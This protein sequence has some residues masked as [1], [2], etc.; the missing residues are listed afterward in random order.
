[1][2]M[3]K[4]L[5]LGIAGLAF[6]ACSNEED[7]INNGSNLNGNGV[8]EVSIVSPT[9]RSLVEGTDEEVGVD[10]VIVNGPI[11]VQL[12]YGN[13]QTKS[14]TI[15]TATGGQHTVKFY[16][17][18]NPTKV[19]A[20][21]NGGNNNGLGTTAIDNSAMQVLPEVIPAYG[22]T[23]DINLAGKTEMVDGKT[24]EM[25]AAE[26]QIAIPVARLEVSGIKHVLHPYTN[27]EDP[28]K[29]EQTCKFATLT[30]D[31]IYLD[32]IKT[33]A[34]DDIEDYCMPAVV[35]SGTEENPEIPY[36]ILYDEIESASFLPTQGVA[37]VWPTTTG[38]VYAYNFY[39]D[40]QMPILKIYFENATAGDGTNPVSA[41][42]YAVIKSY[43][44]N[45]NYQFEAGKI[46][47][48]TDVTL[49]DANIIHSEEGNVTY[50]VDVTVKEAVWDVVDITGEWVEY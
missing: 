47:R 22:S 27:Q 12:T 25:Y 11:T 3:N 31:G 39:P 34:S 42:R 16:D 1:M 24:Y 45:E 14:E 41:P 10:K 35:G 32:K 2:K 7:A 40:T 26:V 15:Q 8:V 18:T 9:T 13:G 48:I 23:E 19:E 38:Q 50:G 33:T 30:I 21:V 29:N 49:R 4:F 43:N 44:G 28:S 46:Y 6:A 5:M 17:I 20:W 37:P 36:P